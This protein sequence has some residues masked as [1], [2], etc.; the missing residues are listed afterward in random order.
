M[1]LGGD[2]SYVQKDTDA[3]Q[4]ARAELQVRQRRRRAGAGRALE[5]AVQAEEAGALL[6]VRP[7]VPERAVPALARC[8]CRRASRAARTTRSRAATRRS[9]RARTR[10]TRCS[11][12]SFSKKF[13]TSGSPAVAV[14]KRFTWSNADQNIVAELDRRRAHGSGQGGAEVGRSR[15]RPRSTSG[16]VSSEANTWGRR[17]APPRLR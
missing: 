17:S 10:A 6:L 13:A 11:R 14:L 3:D 2:P 16:S 4:G 8:S 9:T 1:F 7:A 12:R 5:P 15:T